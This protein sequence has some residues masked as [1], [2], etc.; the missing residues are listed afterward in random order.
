ESEI[1]DLLNDA[2]LNISKHESRDGELICYYKI[3]EP[4]NCMRIAVL[5]RNGEINSFYPTWSQPNTGNN[6]KPFSFF[7]NIGHV[8]SESS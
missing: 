8:I 3:D 7:D 1:L 5:Y 6:G 2:L 4:L